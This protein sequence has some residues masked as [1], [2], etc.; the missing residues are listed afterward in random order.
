MSGL[1]TRRSLVTAGLT[2]AAGAA[3]LGAA[4]HFAGRYAL[5][6]PD[7]GGIIG[8]GETLTYS[9]QRLLTSNHSLAREFKRSDISK[10]PVVNG[11]APVDATFRALRAN[12]FRD[13]RLQVE[14][15]IARPASFSLEELKRL[16]AE[17]H[18]SLHACEQG[19]SY[20]AEWTGLRL[21]SLLDVVK[22]RPEARY[23][24]FIPFANP[25]Q[26]TGEVRV[27][28]ETIDMAD[29]LH[30]QTLLAYGMNGEAL[31]ADFGAPL[32]LRL[33]R[34]LGYKNTKYLSR[35]IVTDRMDF[36][37]KGGGTWYGGI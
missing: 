10:A 32:R 15:L 36:Y 4:I 6:P 12:G 29:A 7:H 14:G 37:R 17:S 20:I 22:T 9:A 34:Q 18:I 24:A 31:P 26:T 23:V 30:P 11:P 27:E 28:W 33:G 16:P 25:R 8:V 21:S 5:I 13:W 2:T 19:W 1:I 35:L 3:G